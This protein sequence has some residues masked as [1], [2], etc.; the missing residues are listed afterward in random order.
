M[1]CARSRGS[2]SERGFLQPILGLAR[3]R[4]TSY[5]THNSTNSIT[6]FEVIPPRQPGSSCTLPLDYVSSKPAISCWHVTYLETAPMPECHYPT[7]TCVF[8]GVG[9]PSPRSAA[10]V[11]RL[12][13]RPK[14]LPRDCRKIRDYTEESTNVRIVRVVSIVEDSERICCVRMND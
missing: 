10:L 4:A 11:P 8:D 14:L 3:S 9:K 7:C 13:R 1:A 2:A 5:V 12:S 6:K